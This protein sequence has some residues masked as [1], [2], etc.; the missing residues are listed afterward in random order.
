MD[1]A[2]WSRERESWGNGGAHVKPVD[3]FMP[4]RMVETAT[5]LAAAATG[6]VPVG[7]TG[8]RGEEDILSTASNA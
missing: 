1:A 4:A 3:L 7:L 2:G 8:T 6:T 5:K